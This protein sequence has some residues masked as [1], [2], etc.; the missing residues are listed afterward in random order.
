MAVVLTTT[1]VAYIANILIDLR[2]RQFFV[3]ADRKT[4]ESLGIELILAPRIC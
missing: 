2:E 4:T 1:I 3:V